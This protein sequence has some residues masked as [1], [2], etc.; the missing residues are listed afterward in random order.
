MEESM[1]GVNP[2]IK[3]QY[4][5][6]QSVNP[7][8]IE[9]PD[10]SSISGT[11]SMAEL[12]DLKGVAAKLNQESDALQDILSTVNKKLSELNIGIEVWNNRGAEDVLCSPGKSTEGWVL[13]YA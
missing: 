5:E 6:H 3:V 12:R 11:Q 1:T 13:G 8:T 9:I 10:L 4:Q 2:H 7:K